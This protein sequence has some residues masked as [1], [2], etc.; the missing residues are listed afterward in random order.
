MPLSSTIQRQGGIGEAGTRVCDAVRAAGHECIFEGGGR[1]YHTYSAYARGNE[2]FLG[3]YLMLDMTPL[4]RQDAGEGL[5]FSY[6]DQ[7][8]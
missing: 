3:T 4:G 7:Y 5:G 2:K 8:E 6:H 1:D